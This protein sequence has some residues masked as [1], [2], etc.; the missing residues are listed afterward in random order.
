[1]I[2]YITYEVGLSSKL[3]QPSLGEFRAIDGQELE[4]SLGGLWACE[5]GGRPALPRPAQNVSD[6]KRSKKEYGDGASFGPAG[7]S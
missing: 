3:K 2:W 5:R 7:V 4:K 6:V 1:M